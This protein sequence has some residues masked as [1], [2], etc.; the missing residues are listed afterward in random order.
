MNTKQKIARQLSGA[1]GRKVTEDDFE[2]ISEDQ[3]IILLTN[4]E[5]FTL[6]GSNTAYVGEGEYL[7]NGRRLTEDEIDR[8]YATRRK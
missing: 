7:A 2:W 3:E 8:H 4:G 6:V 1:L 5:V